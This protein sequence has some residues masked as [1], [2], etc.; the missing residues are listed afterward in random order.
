MSGSR[1]SWSSLIG[2]D[3]NLQ[4]V[5]SPRTSCSIRYGMT[6][7]RRSLGL[8]SPTKCNDLPERRLHKPH[9]S[10][11]S[12]FSH[13]RISRQ[14]SSQRKEKDFSSMRRRKSKWATLLRSVDLRLVVR[15][16]VGRTIATASI[17]VEA[18][19]WKFDISSMK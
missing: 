18:G 7:E 1:T 8:P 10:P 3:S 5:S 6:K 19:L 13:E 2:T 17:W 14:V 9:S 11:G 4:K 15:H 16:R 12:E